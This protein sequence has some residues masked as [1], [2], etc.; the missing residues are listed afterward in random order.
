MDFKDIKQSENSCQKLIDRYKNMTSL[1]ISNNAHKLKS[2]NLMSVLVIIRAKRSLKSLKVDSS[3]RRWSNAAF[4][5]LG[6]IQE[7]S[8]VSI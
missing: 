1:E 5:I 6:Q 3:I 2:L 8:K 4:K 7:S